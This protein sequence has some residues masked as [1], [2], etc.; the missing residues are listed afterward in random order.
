MP[1]A[2]PMELFVAAQFEIDS[3]TNIQTNDDGFTQRKSTRYSSQ[4]ILSGLLVCAE[5]GSNYHRRLTRSS[6]EVVWRCADRV[7]K[8]KKSTC[9]SSPT[10]ADITIKAMI[11]EELELTEFDEQTVQEK[12][13]RISIEGIKIAH[14]MCVSNKNLQL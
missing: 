13:L 6:G 1:Y 2:I 7:K 4:N 11:Y 12:I 14:I 10:I 3:R 9:K 5:C 8:G